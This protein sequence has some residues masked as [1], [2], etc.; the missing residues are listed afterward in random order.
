MNLN[1]VT[2][3]VVEDTSEACLRVVDVTGESSLVQHDPVGAG[4]YH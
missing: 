1:N 2:E 4:Q 3:L